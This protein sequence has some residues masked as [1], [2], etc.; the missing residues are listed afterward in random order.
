MVYSKF[1]SYQ[2][3]LAILTSLVISVFYFSF[4]Y[5]YLSSWIDEKG[6]VRT[7]DHYVKLGIPQFLFNPH[8]IGFDWVGQQFYNHLK[9]KGYT[10]TSMKV[11]QLRNLIVSAIGLGILFFLFYNISKKFLLS[12]LLIGAIAFSCA[13]WIYSQINDT[14]IIHSILVFLL[15]MAALYFPQ[16]KRRFIYASF[17]GLLHAVTIFFHQSDLLM[18]IVV[19]AVMLTGDYFI[20]KFD[21][22]SNEKPSFTKSITSNIKYIITYGVVFAVIVVT[23]YYYVGIVLI[24]LTLDIN[25][26]QSF[27]QIEKSTYFFNWLVLYTKIDY[28]GK[29]FEEKNLLQKIVAGISTYFYQPAQ[30]NGARLDINF[31]TFFNPANILP[32]MIITYIF[33]T[34]II[35]IV[36]IKKLIKRYGYMMIA[37]LLYMIIY[38]VFTCWWEADYREFWVAPMFSFWILSLIIISFIIDECKLFKAI[39]ACF[40]YTFMFIIAFLLFYFN[41]TTFIYPNSSTDLKKIDIVKKIKNN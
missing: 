19:A 23:A 25:K 8:H 29:G 5:N 7:Y 2:L 32:N 21:K 16:C 14:P 12:F 1:K 20:M 13:F 22:N 27:N 35:T 4:N 3:T 33:S 37:I 6:D 10:G 30:F 28:W 9:D 36:F 26:A 38:S 15:F 34:L 17:L 41:F 11:L 18:G 31:K 40:C 39:T 24:G